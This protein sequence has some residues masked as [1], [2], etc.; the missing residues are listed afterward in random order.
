MAGKFV[1][2]YVS[3]KNSIFGKSDPFDVIAGF[4]RHQIEGPPIEAAIE[5]LDVNKND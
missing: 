2:I 1:I 5:A 3:A 4:T